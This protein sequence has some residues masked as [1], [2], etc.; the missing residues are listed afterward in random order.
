MLQD[1]LLVRHVVASVR[2]PPYTLLADM[3]P[4]VESVTNTQA[5]NR[6]MTFVG[7]EGREP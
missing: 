1:S 5:P 6:S 3:R 2:G 4:A 7:E